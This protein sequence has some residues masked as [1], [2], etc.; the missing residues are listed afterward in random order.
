MPIRFGCHICSQHLSATDTESEITCPKCKRTIMVPIRST[1]PSPVPDVSPQHQHR[2]K[3][4]QRA[5][6][7][8]TKVWLSKVFGKIVVIGAVAVAAWFLYGL[9]KASGPAPPQH[10]TAVLKRPTTF[11]L[12][13]RKVTLP[14]GSQIEFV[15]RDESEVR[16]RYRGHQQSIPASDVDLR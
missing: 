7:K 5:L 6:V 14:H 15:S 13:N 2:A 8:R 11:Q 9:H 3:N 4:V 1:L 12:P 10:T 16:V